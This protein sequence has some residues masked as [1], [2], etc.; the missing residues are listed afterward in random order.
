MIAFAT[1]AAGTGSYQFQPNGTYYFSSVSGTHRGWLRGPTSGADFDLYLQKWN[2]ST[3]VTV[4]SG[5]SSTSNEDIVYSGTSGY[6]TFKVY[7]YSG[8]G[9]YDLWIQHP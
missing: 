1:V 8:S 7:S 2:G 4:A 5:T 3:W 9:S 6:Y